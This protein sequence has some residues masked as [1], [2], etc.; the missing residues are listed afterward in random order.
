MLSRNFSEIRKL[1][2]AGNFASALPLLHASKPETDEDAFEAMICLFVSG[3]FEAVLQQ[4]GKHEWRSPWS[5]DAS[6]ALIGLITQKDTREALSL[7]RAAVSEPGVAFDAVALYLILLHANRL[8][9]E[10]QSYILRKLQDPPAEETLL[11]IAM[12]EIAAATGNWAG[13]YS[14]ALSVLSRDLSNFRALLIL[15]LASYEV[16]NVHESLGYA[17]RAQRI[18]PAAPAVVLMLMRCQNKIGDFYAAIAAFKGLGNAE[19]A[20]PEFHTELGIAYSGLGDREKAASAY[21]KA[22]RA[23]RKPVVALRNLLDLHIHSASTK[24][25]WSLAKEHETDIQGDIDC[26]QRLGLAHLKA[27]DLERSFDLFRK[28]FALTQGVETPAR[29][30]VPEPRI[31]H[32]YEQLDLLRQRGRLTGS[33]ALALP[34]L[35]RYYDRTGD[36]A[37]AFHPDADDAG[38]LR[39]ALAKHHYWPDATFSGK[40]LGETD[41]ASEEASYLKNSPS[42]VVIDDFL[43]GAALSELR[44]FCEEATVWKSYFGNGYVGA[45]LS[46]GFCPRVVLAVADELRR[47]MPRVIGDDALIQAWAFKYDQRM[48]GINIHADLAK[49]NVNFWITPDESC[50][51]RETGGMIVYDVPAPRSWSFQD[52]NNNQ[53][54]ID[55]YLKEQGAGSRRVPYRANRCVLF[56]STLFHAT[57]E[58]H[59]KP[60]YTNRRVNV[61]LLFGKALHF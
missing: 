4:V 45:F 23:E 29:W 13:A 38:P 34:V 39:E 10:A 6:R 28:C 27:G 15:S 59:F 55:T 22:L 7:A 52:Y 2:S 8:I 50:D 57:D 26:V 20:P 53:A 1:R 30:P 47:A 9:D 33:A 48:P 25:L 54:K 5:R 60:G 12:G 37:K 24:E 40:A 42:L 31:R 19:T 51:D 41:Y 3:N 32:D 46:E 35:K 43:S 44:R 56:D 36:P 18:V 21:K 11:H 58:L 49:V 17:T 14:L 16:G 61:T